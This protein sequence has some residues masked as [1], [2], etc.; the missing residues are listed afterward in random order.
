MG[1]K[2]VLIT[3]CSEG[4]IGDALAKT[5]HKKGLRVFASARNTAKVQHLKD[6]GLEIV[7]LDVTDEESIKKAVST[8]KAAT[9]GYLD[10][11]VNNS[12]AGS[13]PL[14]DSDVS[15]AKKM[16]D[17]NVFAV[18]TVTQA[19]APLL[20]ASKGTIINI[21]SVLGK[22]PFPWSGY[23]NASK[24]AVA[25][26]T[27][28][29]RLEFSP[30]G[31]RAILVTTGVI[32]T[33]FFDNL[34]SAPRLPENSLYYPAKDVIEPALAG[35]GVEENAMDVNSYA[36]VVV[37]NALRSSPKKH[38]WSG[39]GALITWLASTFGWSTVWDMLLPSAAHLPDITNKIHVAEKA[40]HD[41]QKAK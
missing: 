29:M 41:R 30:W 28:Q 21:G 9:G 33:K 7:Q 25:I 5:F 17:V 2:T 11:L 3:G 40:E 35:A 26:M 38:L 31:V 23:Y 19:F 8:V 12:G 24:A 13:M 14:L 37:N 36:E 39:G 10:I 27:D 1:Q 18:G 34:P 22:M 20:I 6:M 4:G 16:F 32:R 15:V